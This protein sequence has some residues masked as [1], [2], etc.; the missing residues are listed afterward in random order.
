[1]S[2]V[3]DSLFNTFAA[4]L[5]TGGRSSFRNLRTRH[6]VVTAT[7]L[8]WKYIC[9]TPHFSRPRLTNL[10]HPYPKWHAEMFPW[11]PALFSSQFFKFVFLDQFLEIVKNVYI[12]IYIHIHT[13]IYTYMYIYIYIYIHTHIHTHIYTHIHT[14]T[15]TCTCTYIYIHIHTQ[16]MN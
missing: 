9:A 5:H 16:K 7:Q 6:A 8:S 13:Y 3:L 4:T 10:L 11:H 1:M 14:Y 12:Y 2:A 15:R